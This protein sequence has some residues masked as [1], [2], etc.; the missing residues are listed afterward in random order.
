MTR[1][2]MKAAVPVA[3]QLAVLVACSADPSEDGGTS[4][5]VAPACVDGQYRETLPDPSASIA[6]QMAGAPSLAD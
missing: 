2:A 5:V 4:T 3:L 1:R 6:A